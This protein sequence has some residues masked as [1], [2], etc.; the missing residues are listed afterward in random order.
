MR[1]QTDDT[2]VFACLLITPG[3]GE[4]WEYNPRRPVLVLV[5]KGG[6]TTAAMRRGGQVELST[7]YRKQDGSCR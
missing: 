3:F 7:L 1:K 6:W 2:L 5:L 4:T